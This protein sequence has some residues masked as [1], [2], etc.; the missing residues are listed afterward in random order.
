MFAGTEEQIE[1]ALPFDENYA[2]DQYALTVT[3]DHPAVLATI[4]E[5]HPEYAVVTVS[6]L[7][8]GPAPSGML[9]WI[10]VGFRA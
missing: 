10:A 8:I 5:K 6:R 1:V 3:A 7:R 9:N 2:D 4:R